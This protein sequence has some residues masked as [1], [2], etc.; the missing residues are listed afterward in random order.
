MSRLGRLT[1]L[2]VGVLTLTA[3]AHARAQ[4]P[5]PPTLPPGTGLVVGQVVDG[6]TG[7]GISSAVVTLAGSRRVM[8]TSDGRFVFRN[9]PEGT[10]T[11]SAGKSGYLDGAFGARRPGGPT[12][13]ITLADG[14]RRGDIVIRLWRHGSI[15]GMVVDEAGEPL[16]GIQITAMRRAT[17]GGRRRFMPGGTAV[18]DDRGLYR[19]ARLVPGD[20]VVAMTT[21]QISVPAT[22]MRQYED[23]MFSGSDLARSPL[24]QA[25]MQIGSSPGM[26]GSPQSRQVGDQVQTL[27]MGAPTPPPADSPKLFAYPTV[28]YPGAPSAAAATIVTVG[29]AQERSGVDLQ[30]R[31]VPTARVSGTV[32]GSAG[33]TTNVPVR[34]IPRGSEVLGRTA[35][36]GGTVTD[37]NGNFTFLGVP[38]G[39][40]TLRIMQIPRPAMPS[41]APTTIQFGTGMGMI[42]SGAPSP[43]PPPIP[44]EPTLWGVVPVVVSDADV[45]GIS[46]VLRP[47]LRISGRVEFDGTAEK[48][49]P[50]Q[51]SRIPVI[52]EPVDGQ[53]DRMTTPPGRVDSGGQFNTVGFASGKYFIRV[54][55]PPPGWTFKGAFLGDRDVSDVPLELESSDVSDVVITFTD[56]PASLGGTVQVTERAARDGVAVIV[57][58]AD[59]KSWMDTGTNPRRMRKVAA[60]DSGAYQVPGLPPG[61]YYVAAIS[62][63]AESDWQ[64]PKF[65]ELLVATAAHVRIDDGE[66]ATQN[67][68]LQ[69]SR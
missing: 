45:T 18:T 44:A 22:T 67:L 2:L 7:K 29:S 9:L 63:A 54:G 59:S 52:I 28:F 41:T 4:P 53:V 1:P 49:T 58:P 19:I 12:L 31:P 35:D 48:P 62:E 11:L 46:V 42:M 43:E 6:V 16:I 23:A 55:G 38:A 69:E 5:G 17:V 61:E 66:K 51:L 34:L 25:M 57:F 36:A 8:T 21:S 40:Y 56:R 14:E 37:A 32:A 24:L 27:S 60:T 30:V 65:L 50:E 39:D 33:S 26:T 13:P 10:H 20:Y 64:D 68:R 3:P 47:G 15:T